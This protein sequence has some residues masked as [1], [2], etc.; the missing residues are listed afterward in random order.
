MIRSLALGGTLCLTLGAVL[1]LNAPPPRGQA[2]VGAAAPAATPTALRPTPSPTAPPA[3]ALLASTPAYGGTGSV[4]FSYARR[5][6]HPGETVVARVRVTSAECRILA[7][8]RGAAWTAIGAPPRQCR[9][10]ALTCAWRLPAT[11]PLYQWQGSTLPITTTLGVQQSADFYAV[12][13]RAQAVLEARVTT[14]GGAPFANLPLHLSGPISAT[15]T[16]DNNGFAVGLLPN[17]PY[18]VRLDAGA[19]ANPWF[20]PLS[21][22]LTVRDV[23]HTQITGYNR[24]RLLAGVASVLANGLQAITLTVRTSNPFGQPVPSLSA[25]TQVSG[26]PAV[27]CALTPGQVGYLQPQAIVDGTPRYLPV[28][29]MADG[30]GL[31]TYQ[32]FFGGEP[33]LWRLTVRESALDQGDPWRGR[34]S[35]SATVRVQPVHWAASMPSRL[36]VPLYHAHGRPTPTSLT[37]SQEIWYALHGKT[38]PVTLPAVAGLTLAPLVIGDPVGSQKALL[39]WLEAFVPLPG[40][41]IGPVF[42]GGATTWGVA[43]F[44]HHQFDRPTMTRVLDVD[45]FTAIVNATSAARLPGLPT[46]AAWAART[47]SAVAPGYADRTSD[48]GFT[49]YGMPYLPRADAL[50]AS[51]AANCLQRAP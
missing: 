51:F 32:V 2:Q 13:P 30:S 3:V 24:L 39:R 49:Y 12:I 41:E 43:I 27:L 36:T 5:Y 48:A 42:T 44:L 21:Q 34:L 15:L 9:P 26:P 29:H 16:T 46:L 20:R 14:P 8:Y 38:V 22:N 4:T 6:Y 1:M 17:G 35:V 40:L 10:S 7:C 23:V 50:F 25:E 18:R 37:L 28:T 33:G 31:L 11:V 45:T 47:R 19:V